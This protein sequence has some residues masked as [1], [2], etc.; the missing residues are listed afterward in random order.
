MMPEEA[1]KFLKVSR[2]TLD[3]MRKSGRMPE[4]CYLELS[5]NGKKII[6]YIRPAIIRWALERCRE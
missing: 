2:P 4:K 1:A 3:E 5:G 6:R